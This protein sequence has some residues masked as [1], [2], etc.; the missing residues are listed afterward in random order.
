MAE[1]R[2][3]IPGFQEGGVPVFPTLERGA[4]ALRNA[5]DYWSFRRG[6]EAP[7]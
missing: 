4:L 5:L 6:V 1:A 3:T 7:A 2:E